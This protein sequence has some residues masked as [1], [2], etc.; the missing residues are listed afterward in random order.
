MKARILLIAILSIL[1]TSSLYAQVSFYWEPFAF[2]DY[3]TLAEAQNDPELFN[4][5]AAGNGTDDYITWRLYVQFELTSGDPNLPEQVV[6]ITGEQESLTSDFRPLFFDFD[7]CPYQHS[8]GSQ[9]LGGNISAVGES[10]TPSLKY[11]S[12]VTIGAHNDAVPSGSLSTIG[13]NWEQLFETGCEL[14][15]DDFNG[16]GWYNVP[17]QPTGSPNGTADENDRVLIA[18]FTIPIGCEL[19][20]AQLCLQ[21]WEDGIQSP[22]T[23]IID[24][25]QVTQPDDCFT[26]PIFSEVQNVDSVTCYDGNDGLIEVISNV[27]PANM[28]ITIDA[29]DFTDEG[30]GNFGGLSA[31]EYTVTFTD[32]NN[33]DLDGLN[34][35]T[36][37]II[38]VGQP[39][40]PF[41][42][43]EFDLSVTPIDCP[44]ACSGIIDIG[45]ILDLYDMST[46]VIN[47]LSALDATGAYFDLCA[48]SYNITITSEFG[49]EGD[50][51]VVLT[52]PNDFVLNFTS[53]ESACSGSDDGKATITVSGGTEPYEYCLETNCNDTGEF[54]SLAPGSYSYSI[55]DDEDCSFTAPDPI[56]ITEPD[57]IEITDLSITPPGCGGE[58]TALASVTAIGGTPGYAYSWNGNPPITGS[59]I[60]ENLCG[61]ENLLRITDQNNCILDTLFSIAQ[62]QAIEVFDNVTNATCT[63]MCDGSFQVVAV[64][65]EPLTIDYG[66][67]SSNSLT[68]LCEGEYP[69]VITDSLGCI[70][71]DTVIVGV[72]IISDIEYTVFTT[73]VSCWNEADGTATIAVTGGMGEIMYQW[74][75][76]NLQVTATAIGLKED[77]Y[78]VT[79]TDEVGCT[80][81]QSLFIDPT[82]G[83]FFVADALTPNG[84]GFNDEWIIGGLEY[85]PEAKV[86]V[87]NRW[88]QQV[89]QSIGTYTNWD[90]EIQQQ[91]TSYC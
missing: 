49:C 41:L 66:A 4:L 72:E 2:H 16:G 24:C 44:N 63:G 85:F 39:D 1:F 76:A 89:F 87:F 57:P 32:Q 53:T 7:C 71:L 25:I 38:T 58:C 67:L 27:D 8:I 54:D 13:S 68:D 19:S 65:L 36:T 29:A 47:P 3:A 40:T 45:D 20:E 21:Y 90:G 61:G 28:V 80:F 26:F 11:D 84:D 78:T 70:A 22:E 60:G 43:D 50:T 42:E 18:Q 56:V 15:I 77:F 34:C 55:T 30:H 10:F 35:S 5:S 6:S 91:S 59:F 9:V 62:P 73:P 46:A 83:C 52:G 86:E 75:D 12:W 51:T 17:P 82:E 81:T 64:G 74:S 23:D 37:E 79:I 31:G 69:L 88:G 14:R 48:G 33:T